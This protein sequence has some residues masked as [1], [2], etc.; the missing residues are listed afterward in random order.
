M[1]A[2]NWPRQGPLLLRK[3][4]D[5]GPSSNVVGKTKGATSTNGGGAGQS[6]PGYHRERS[7]SKAELLRAAD[8]ERFPVDS[9][10]LCDQAADL[11]DLD[12]EIHLLQG[13]DL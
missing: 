6:R 11:C 12:L 2:R 8:A 7:D 13:G 9:Q 1:M 10:L 3:M 5:A 4:D